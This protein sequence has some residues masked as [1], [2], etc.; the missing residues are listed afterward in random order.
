MRVMYI[1]MIADAV[2][3]ITSGRPYKQPTQEM[4]D[5]ITILRNDEGKYHPE[6]LTWLEN[7][8]Q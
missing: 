7:I 6:Y 4:K 5:A 2:D 8:L 3:A 1:V